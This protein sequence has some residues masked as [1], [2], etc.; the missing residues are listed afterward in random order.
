MIGFELLISDDPPT[1][2]SQSARIT[3]ISH[4]A[5]PIVPFLMINTIAQK[6]I[7]STSTETYKKRS[8]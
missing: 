2:A 6:P 5:W 4:H 3:G 1:S 8:L 7:V